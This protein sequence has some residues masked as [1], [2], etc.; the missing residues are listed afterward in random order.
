MNNIETA[1]RPAAE[2]ETGT[3]VRV[4]MILR[5]IAEPQAG[6]TMKDLA[7]ELNLPMSTIHR[8]LELLAK[9]GMVERDESTKSFLPG[10]EFFRL[11]ARVVHRMPIA[12][13][14]RSFLEAAMRDAEESA[15]LGVLDLKAC[16]MMFA[17][18]A[19]SGQLLDYRMPMNTPLSL[20]VGASGLSILSWMSEDHIDRV[21]MTEAREAGS[22]KA[23]PPREQLMARLADIRRVGY[24]N[25]F[26]ERIKGAVGFFAPVFDASRAVRGCFGFTVPRVR[27]EEI[28]SDHLA[29]TILLHA[30]GLS[31]ALG[32]TGDYPRPASDYQSGVTADR[33]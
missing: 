14:A 6:V 19:E 31:A 26:G 11:A 18:H 2:R 9:E 27:F 33:A 3:I 17:T 12:A 13:L 15:Y 7:E 24:A 28:T 32:Y 25:T 8:L 21:L 29:R 22:L 30:G 1:G 5:A 16:K 4:V 23:L 10:L 20:A